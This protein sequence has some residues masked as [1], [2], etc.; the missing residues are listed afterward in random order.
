MKL[1]CV[2]TS[3]LLQWSSILSKRYEGS[4]NIVSLGITIEEVE[5]WCLFLSFLVTA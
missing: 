2:L 1:K 4:V 5:I 3:V